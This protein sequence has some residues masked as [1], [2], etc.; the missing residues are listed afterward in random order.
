MKRYGIQWKCMMFTEPGADGTRI[1][2]NKAVDVALGDMEPI[3]EQLDDDQLDQLVTTLSKRIKT[4]R[5][6]LKVLWGAHPEHPYAPNEYT[7]Q[8]EIEYAAFVECMSEHDG[9]LEAR[10]DEE[11]DYLLEQER[12][13][14]E[15]VLWEEDDATE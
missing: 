12:E 15:G 10:T 13:E 5:K 3:L 11:V 2:A 4:P 6:I 1:D 8:T 14:N 7:F 9:W